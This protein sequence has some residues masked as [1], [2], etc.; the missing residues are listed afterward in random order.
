M[1]WE[2]KAKMRC[3]YGSAHHTYI[4]NLLL[5]SSESKKS[6]G[7]K[8]EKMRKRGR[9]IEQGKNLI[10]GASRPHKLYVNSIH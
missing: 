1:E 4:L 6:I 3:R 5:L 8:N 7:K 10:Q 9:G 2:E